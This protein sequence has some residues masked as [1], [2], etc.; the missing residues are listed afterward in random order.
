[1]ASGSL[2]GFIDTL[3]QM[4]SSIPVTSPTGAPGQSDILARLTTLNQGG[5]TPF[6]NLAASG[7]AAA[8]KAPELVW[9]GTRINTKPNPRIADTEA[10]RAQAATANGAGGRV[11]VTPDAAA[12][13]PFTWSE[14]ERE[15]A[16]QRVSEA[17]G[18]PIQSF[19][20][21]N[22]I[23][24]NAVKTAEQSWAATSGGKNGS[25]LTVWDVFDLA[26][27]E[28]AK[29]GY[30][31]GGAGGTTV[32]TSS[33]VEKLSDGTMWQI[34]K[35]TA[36][37]AL[38]RAPT[39]DELQ[40]FASRA[41]QVASANPTKSRTVTTSSSGGSTS[42]TTTQQGASAG[43]YELA[44]EN[45]INSNPEAGAFQAATTYA[46]ALFRGIQSVV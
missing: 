42:N 30:E 1:M 8:P 17:V 14:K 2:F 20:Q 31:G 32:S 19:Q 33:S 25:P 43:D 28:G 18:E 36:T 37:Q 29:Y 41:N 9:M 38:G 35:S 26:K 27:R 13:L 23:W 24:A 44:A 10:Y 46:D 15:A 40:R 11:A 45:M 5:V 39:N 12:N 21:F 34:M 7:G 22:S 4:A 3:A 16:Y 6:A